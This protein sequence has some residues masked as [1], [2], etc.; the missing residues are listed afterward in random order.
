MKWAQATSSI[1]A[2]P[3][4]SSVQQLLPR[5]L[6][7]SESLSNVENQPHNSKPSTSLSNFQKCSIF[8]EHIDQLY[9]I[10]LSKKQLIKIH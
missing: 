1:W 6:E 4:L 10:Y 3:S 7:R 5:P 9:N 8:R 2:D